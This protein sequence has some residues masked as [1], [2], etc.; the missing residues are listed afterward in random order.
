MN[1]HIRFTTHLTNEGA[2]LAFGVRLAQAVKSGVI[3]YL[4][5]QLGAGKT[6]LTRGFLRGLGYQGKVKSPTF[7]LVEPYEVSGKKIFHFDFY[8]LDH[9]EE[10]M[11]IGIAEYF[12]PGSVCLIEWPEKGYPV[13]PEADLICHIAIEP[14]G[15][16]LRLEA[17]SQRGD[18]ILKLL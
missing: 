17:R 15:R 8:R 18:E 11:H 7:T 12:D 16:S 1:K 5:G 13:L 10:L 14:E 4:D 6:T 9:P 2:T 3:L